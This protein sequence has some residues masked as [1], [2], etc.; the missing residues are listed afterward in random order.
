M[1][2]PPP[3]SQVPVQHRHLASGLLLAILPQLPR[4]AGRMFR[5]GNGS[6]KNHVLVAGGCTFMGFVAKRA[7]QAGLAAHPHLLQDL[8]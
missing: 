4:V 8:H 7:L 1:V 6:R 3:F 5:A 2:W